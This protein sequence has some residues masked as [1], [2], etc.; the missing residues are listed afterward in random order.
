M[1]Y[2]GKMRKIWV[3]GPPIMNETF[4]KAFDELKDKLELSLH[5]IDIM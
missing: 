2:K 1:P 5:E 3:S 4:D